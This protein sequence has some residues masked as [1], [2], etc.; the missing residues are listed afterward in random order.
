MLNE[1][2]GKQGKSRVRGFIAAALSKDTQWLPWQLHLALLILQFSSQ[3]RWG[4]AGRKRAGEKRV[5]EKESSIYH[6]DLQSVGMSRLTET[7]THVSRLTYLN[8][9]WTWAHR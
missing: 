9:L 6:I 7:F 1:E 2:S 3:E 5:R 8:V 4:R